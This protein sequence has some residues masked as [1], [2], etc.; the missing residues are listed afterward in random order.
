[1]NTDDEIRIDSEGKYQQ[2]LQDFEEQ[3]HTNHYLLVK[4]KTG[5]QATGKQFRALHVFCQKLADTLN[6]AGLGLQVVTEMGIDVPWDKDSVKKRL[7]K[8]IQKA[9]TGEASTKKAGRTDYAKVQEILSQQLAEKFGI[10]CPA[11]PKK[12]DEDGQF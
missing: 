5:K 9:L 11:W 12:D 2:F 1:M 10:E 8:P 4:V 7:F 6:A 3:W